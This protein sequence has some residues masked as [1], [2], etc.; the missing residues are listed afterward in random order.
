MI[1]FRNPL[2]IFAGLVLQLQAISA[3]PSGDT[4]VYHAEGKNRVHLE[5]CK[6]LPKEPAERA[7]FA[8]ITYAEAKAKNLPLCS[9]CPGSTTPGSDKN[10]GIESWVKPGPKEIEKVA[11]TPNPLAPLISMGSDGKLVYKP[12]SDKGDRLMDW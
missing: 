9:R 7:T 12:Y 8:K 10:G 3:E 6:R 5:E 11:F 4:T 2:L 1:P